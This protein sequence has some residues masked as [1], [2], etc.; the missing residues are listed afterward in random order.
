MLRIFWGMIL[1][2][3]TTMVLLGGA[4]AADQ[5][6]ANSQALYLDHLNRFDT[7][8][9]LTLLTMVGLSFGALALWPDK[10]ALDS[11]K[12]IKHLRRHC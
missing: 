1:G 2:S 4:S 7:P 10:S 9:T 11:E 6:I 12:F 8:T 3:M 5:V